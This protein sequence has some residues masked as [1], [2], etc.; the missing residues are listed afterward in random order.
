MTKSLIP[1]LAL[2]IH[3]QATM[4]QAQ[5]LDL[6]KDTPFFQKQAQ[7]YQL[8]LDQS[9]LG[10]VLRVHLTEVQPTGLALYLEF[11]YHNID[12]IGVAW[13]T[14]KRKFDAERASTL[15]Q[16]LFYKMVFLMDV[17]D[18]LANVQLYN[19]YDPAGTT[20]FFRGI[21][22]DGKKVQVDSSGSRAADASFT[23][24]LKDFKGLTKAAKEP[25]NANISKSIVYQRIFS[26]A[27]RRYANKIQAD[28]KPR[29]EVR[30]SL[31]TLRFEVKDLTREVLTDA[32]QPSWCKFLKK[33]GITD[34]NWVKREMLAFLVDYKETA[35]G[36]FFI[37]ITIDGKVGSGYY[38]KI[39]DN[40]YRTMDADFKP[41]LEKYAEKFR[42][43]VRN[44]LLT[45]RP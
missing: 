45:G 3:L 40:A 4:S 42:L 36:T 21:F 44:Y 25:V 19:T 12:S 26:F 9:G 2:F 29:L 15:E 7:A 20:L 38:A 13:K 11:Q 43:E 28:R 39:R 5:D 35:P 33:W 32:E 17:P 34:C 27:K 18:T 23:I 30:D 1:F 31:E 37:S 41:Y 8:W 22:F 14:L 6:S 24:Q 16:T 10:S